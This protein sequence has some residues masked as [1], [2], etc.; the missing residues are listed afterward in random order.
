MLTAQHT[1]LWW[2]CLEDNMTQRQ[3]SISQEAY[4]DGKRIGRKG[5]GLKGGR[6]RVYDYDAWDRMM[7]G[8]RWWAALYPNER[9]D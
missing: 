4:E 5:L 9:E 8:S 6:R 7:R 1:V 3:A 2:L